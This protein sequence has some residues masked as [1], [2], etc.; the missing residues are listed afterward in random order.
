MTS[1]FF[2]EPPYRDRA[3]AAE[4]LA[5]AL[6]RWRGTKP[7]I[8]AIPRGAVPMG[9]IVADRLHGELDV[10]L[11]RK[12]RAPGNPELAVGAVDET[13]WTYIADFA[14]SAGASEAYLAREIED[15]IA[16]IR[17]RRSLYTPDRPPLDA[18][19]RTVIVVD[20]GLATGATMIAAL[21]AM[22]SRS[23]ARLVCA[24]PVASPEA[25]AKVAS[26]ADE[27]VVLQAPESF[28]AVAQF[29]GAF[30]Q[31]EDDE[32]VRLLRASRDAR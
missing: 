7:L 18:A 30:P 32:V 3:D 27:V 15:Q 2:R 5:V 8:A 6:D 21:H 16:T 12:L 11:T 24:V 17:R 14:R 9:R 26:Y 4:R 19:G 28:R 25:A 13:G 29:Y 22:R 31:I 10:V 20:D 1:V 23:P